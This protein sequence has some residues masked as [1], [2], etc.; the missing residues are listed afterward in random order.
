VKNTSEG[1]GLPLAAGFAN[2]SASSFLLISLC[3][4]VNPLNCF[5]R[6]HIANKYCTRIGSLAVK[7]FS[8]CRAMI[9]E[10]V[11]TMHVVTPRALS[12]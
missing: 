7:Y 6:L 8:I 4:S 2:M 11:L 10:S 12:L 1:R 9:L 3:W 5:S